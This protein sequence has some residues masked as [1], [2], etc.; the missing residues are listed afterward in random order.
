[1]KVAIVTQPYDKLIPPDQS[2]MGLVAYNTAIEMARENEVTVYGR[3]R[4]GFET[5][6]DLPFAISFVSGRAD[7]MLQ[8]VATHYPRWARRLGITAIADG[9]RGYAQS[10]AR[11]LDHSECDVV[12][13]MNYWSW[14]RRLRGRSC[15]RPIVLEM[16]SEW[17]SQ[18]D[19]QQV[20][21]ELGAADALVAIS[22]HIAGLIRRTFPNYKGEVATAY[23]GVSVEAF[24]PD[25]PN[26]HRDGTLNVLFVGRVSPE[27]GVHTLIEAFAQIASRIANARLIIVGSRSTLRE[28]FIV[29]ISSD[30]LVRALGRFYNGSV[31]TNYQQYLDSLVSKLN[32]GNKVRFLGRVPHEDMPKWY[33]SSSVVVNPSLSE[34]FGISIVEGMASGVPVVGAK[35]GGM[36]ETIADG[37]TGLL[38]KPERPDLLADAVISLLEN[39]RTSVEM[40]GK[41]RRRVVEHFSWRARVDRLVSIYDR[42]LERGAASG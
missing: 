10:V 22:D 20:G 28:D 41:G 27:K 19:E 38:V 14:C 2:S 33:Q 24:R 34:S 23:N 30:P 8:V 40:G 15:R 18:M 29:S 37:E 35:V 39:P 1:M 12:H 25:F 3:R 36:L 16:H 7:H 6:H 9:Y 17:L 21:R 26:G 32:L 13:I 31:S 11:A 5:P 42:V 4:P